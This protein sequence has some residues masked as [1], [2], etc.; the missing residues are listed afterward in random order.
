MEG[1]TLPDQH[2][3]ARAARQSR[4]MLAVAT[5]IVLVSCVLFVWFAL[6]RDSCTGGLDRAPE[7]VLR[8]YL[9]AIVNEKGQR[10][11]RCWEAQA[12]YDLDAGC[13][14]ICLARILGTHFEIVSLDL[15][16]PYAEGNRMRIRALVTAS[17][18]SEEILHSGEIVLD[19]TGWNAPWRHWRI[20]SSTFG[21]SATAPWCR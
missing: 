10:L 14:D 4:L 3:S 21:G 8:S 7:S 13:S 9:D 18:P 15:S 12:F 2:W 1:P 20:V 5:S 16:E 19:S 6:Y 17:C 11:T